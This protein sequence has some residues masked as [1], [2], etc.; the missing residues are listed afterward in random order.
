MLC[1]HHIYNLKTAIF[2]TGKFVPLQLLAFGHFHLVALNHVRAGI[3]GYLSSATLS[4]QADSIHGGND[5]L[6]II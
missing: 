5:G 1:Y 4:I 2:A 6:R 3:S